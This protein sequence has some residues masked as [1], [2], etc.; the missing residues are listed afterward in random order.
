MSEVVP[1]ILC[2][3]EVIFDFVKYLMHEST[4]E[5][6]SQFLE[7]KLNK[8]GKSG[9][10]GRKRGWKCVNGGTWMDSEHESVR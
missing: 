4:I 1:G 7:R 10:V 3:F 2:Y 5:M 6:R 8:K 9:R